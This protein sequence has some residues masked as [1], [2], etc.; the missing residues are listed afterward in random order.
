ME[1]RWITD[2]EPSERWPHHTRSNAGE[3]DPA[4]GEANG[5]TGQVTVLEL[6][7]DR[8]PS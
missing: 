8:R 6:P 5:D 1:D 2:W 4:D 7:S 3:V